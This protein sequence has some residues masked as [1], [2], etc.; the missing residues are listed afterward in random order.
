M[1]KGDRVKIKGNFPNYPNGVYATIIR[2]GRGKDRWVINIDG[3][4]KN[5]EFGEKQFE[6]E[7]N[8]MHS[9]KEKT[10]KLNIKDVDGWDI[11][12]IFEKDGSKFIRMEGWF[13]FNDEGVQFNSNRRCEISIEE[14]MNHK[15]FNEF[16]YD[17]TI[18]DMIG[19][20]KQYI[21]DYDNDV[22]AQND[23]DAMNP[24]VLFL[25]DLNEYV[26]QGMYIS[27]I[28]EGQCI[29]NY[30]GVSALEIAVPGGFLRA[31]KS[32]DPEYPGI[33]VEF[34]ASV[35]NKHYGEFLSRPR[36]LTEY[37]IEDNELRTLIWAD[38]T[39]EDYSEDISFEKE[40]YK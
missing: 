17:E 3:Q 27:P 22:D 25:G 26:P 33:D 24:T 20:C 11:Y 39:S 29:S 40:Y 15:S 30:N 37:S 38:K 14:F 2:K 18:S 7:K 34:I 28:K 16:G 32:T 5:V 9:A 36:V 31:I 13:Y 10:K 21:E 12:S 35:E 6:I 4:T 8:E 1:K 19:D 23:L